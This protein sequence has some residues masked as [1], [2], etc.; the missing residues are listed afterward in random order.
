VLGFVLNIMI[1]I[2]STA[3]GVIGTIFGIFIALRSKQVFKP[4]LKITVGICYT[5]E[6]I[7]RS[8]RSKK[9]TTLFYGVKIPENSYGYFIFPFCIENTSKLPISDIRISL[10]YPPKNIVTEEMI[11]NEFLIK[12][13]ANEKIFRDVTSIDETEYGCV[14]YELPI[15]RPGE[16]IV[17]CDCIKFSVQNRD[18]TEKTE[19]S[20]HNNLH[21]RM[22]KIDNLIDFFTLD[23]NTY[24]ATCNPHSQ[25]I[26]VFCFDTDNINDVIKLAKT[27]VNIFWGGKCPKPGIYFKPHPWKK[28]IKF[29]L[30]E[31]TIPILNNIHNGTNQIYIQDFI[32]SESGLVEMMLPTCNYYL[33]KPSIEQY[34]SPIFNYIT[35]YVKNIKSKKLT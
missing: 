6:D 2:I 28:L 30:G 15:I 29:E 14:T 12:I 13:I 8:F 24:A 26:N 1:E 34:Y 3:F 25:R 5:R 4:E 20:N 33:E 21:E 18:S 7:P 32:K 10:Y 23:I 9:I 16:Q 35:T 22:N 11:Q 31:I 19:K 17:I 27:A